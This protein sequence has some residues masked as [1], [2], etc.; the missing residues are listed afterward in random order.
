M[1]F[2]LTFFAFN[3][4]KLYIQG[5]KNNNNASIFIA[6]NK[7][8]S[9]VFSLP[10]KVCRETDAECS[11]ANCST[12][13]NQRNGCSFLLSTAG[14]ICN[15]RYNTGRLCQLARRGERPAKR[16]CVSYHASLSSHFTQMA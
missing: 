2:I 12:Q 8:S 15:V 9:N 13:E 6:K 3:P 10:A 14:S 1:T 16:Q 4:W 5:Y 7:P 11:L